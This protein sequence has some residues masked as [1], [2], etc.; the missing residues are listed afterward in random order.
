MARPCSRRLRSSFPHRA[1]THHPISRQRRTIPTLCCAERTPMLRRYHVILALPLA[2]V[3]S[4]WLVV[5][6]VAQ[7]RSMPQQ[8]GQAYSPGYGSPPQGYGHNPQS[9]GYGSQPQGY[10]SQVQGYGP[11]AQG[12]P[13]QVAPPS[14]LN[15]GLW[16]N[17]PPG[18]LRPFATTAATAAADATTARK[19][20]GHEPRQ[21]AGH[22]AQRRHAASRG[23][24][25][26]VAGQSPNGA[27]AG[28]WLDVPGSNSKPDRSDQP[29]GA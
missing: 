27:V 13:G 22:G 16:D 18:P 8:P 14:L 12:Q 3:V 29:P 10:G 20:S 5:S 25:R 11:P 15:N 19:P 2:I 1:P 26:H 23:P 17:V 28:G 7:Q 6:V 9:Q 4:A 24:R 21:S